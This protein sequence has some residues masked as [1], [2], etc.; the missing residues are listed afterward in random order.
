M[1]N[2]IN[3]NDLW[4][5]Q[6]S[7]IPNSENLMSEIKKMKQLNLR[8]LV[9]ANFLLITTSAFIILI[10]IYYQP[11]WITT[12]IGIILIIL[13]MAIYLLAYNKSYSL[14]RDRM[15]PQSNRDYL[16][17]LLAIKAKQ[18]FMQTTMLNLYFVLLSAGISLYMY[19][20]TSRMT[21]FWAIFTYGI[22]G[23]WVFLNWFYFR[24]RQ[25]NK[26]LS[27]LDEIIS[28]IEMLNEQLDEKK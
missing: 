20:Y 28:K 23:L 14:F 6:T 19:E 21:A 13:A 22:T 4:A 18:L 17:D 2:N 1:D 5:K 3:L 25:I 7:V 24:P 26:Q 10:W 12:K 11:Q 16:K 9:L 8:R 15:N 27:K